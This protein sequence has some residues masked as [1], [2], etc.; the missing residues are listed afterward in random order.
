MNTNNRIQSLQALRT[1]AFIGVVLSH[2]AIPC[3]GDIRM[4]VTSF[5][6]AP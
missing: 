5:V 3:W 1:L 4:N 6:Y 2:T